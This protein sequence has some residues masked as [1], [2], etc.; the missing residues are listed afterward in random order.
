MKSI[1]LLKTGL[2]GLFAVAVGAVVFA[3]DPT[4]VYARVDKVVLEPTAGSPDTIQLWGVF[5]L[6]K[7]DDRN[8]YLPAARG[9]LF[10]KLMTDADNTRKEWADLQ[11]VA[12]TGQIVSFGSRYQLHPPLRRPNERPDHPD[13]YAI[14]IGITKVR[15]NTTYAPIRALLEFRN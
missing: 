13:P 8:E 2:L 5:S 9:Y 12:G 14:S 15:G 7:P 1:R 10:F 4:A 3:S 11:Q 6:A